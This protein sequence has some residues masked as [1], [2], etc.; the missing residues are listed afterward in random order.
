M[1]HAGFGH[2]YIIGLRPTSAAASFAQFANRITG[3]RFIVKPPVFGCD[4]DLFDCYCSSCRITRRRTYLQQFVSFFWRFT[5][6]PF[7]IATTFDYTVQR[8]QSRVMFGRFL[9]STST[10]AGQV[11]NS[12]TENNCDRKGQNGGG[13]A[14]VYRKNLK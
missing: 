8:V 9:V 14:A 2:L 7:C 13:V 6:K 5:S 11:L 4:T 3:R 1:R 12:D 10:H